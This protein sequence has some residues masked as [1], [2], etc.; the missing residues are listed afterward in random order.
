M[1][2]K[3]DRK[4]AFADDVETENKKARSEEEPTNRSYNRKSRFKEK[5]S[6]DSDEEDNEQ[7]S[8]KLDDEEIEGQE[9]STV[10]YDDG[11]KVTPFNLKEEMEDGFFDSH[12][13]YFTKDKGQDQDDNWLTGVDWNQVEELQALNAEKQKRLE[14]SLKSD[15]NFVVVDKEE[16]LKKML[17]IL[18]PGETVGKALRRLGGKTTMS[19]SERWKAKKK[20]GVDKVNKE[21]EQKRREVVNTLTGYADQLLTTGEYNIYE[22]TY[23]KIKYRTEQFQPPVDD[24]DAL[25]RFA[26]AIDEKK[27][28]SGGGG[29][30]T[31]DQVMWEYKWTNTEDAE[32]FGPYSSDQMDEWN[33]AEFFKDGVWVRRLDK[34]DSQFYNSKRIDFELYT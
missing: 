16:V 25:D 24:D 30:A 31:Q 33:K 19:A 2:T 11:I 4:V 15:D 17:E 12:G 10:D 27:S 22:D 13:N 14:E 7:I 1:A 28:A 32:T 26:D 21:E 3:R 34:Q 6:L 9:E 23:E 29:G 5:H 18:K 8:G 20:G